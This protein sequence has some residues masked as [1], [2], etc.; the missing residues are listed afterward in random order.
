MICPHC[1]VEMTPRPSGTEVC[2]SCFRVATQAQKP[3]PPRP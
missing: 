2:P 1:K 3:V